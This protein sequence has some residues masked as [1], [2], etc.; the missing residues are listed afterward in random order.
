[1]R[2]IFNV[3]NVRTLN[4]EPWDAML[5]LITDYTRHPLF[6]REAGK[7]LE[8]RQLPLL[9]LPLAIERLRNP[10]LSNI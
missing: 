3:V 2:V 5:I 6:E 4:I 7:T 8:Q 1:M 9:L 10:K